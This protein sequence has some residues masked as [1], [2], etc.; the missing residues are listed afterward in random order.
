MSSPVVPLGPSRRPQGLLRLR[1]PWSRAG[2]CSR[3]K[4]AQV[5]RVRCVYGPRRG[6]D[7]AALAPRFPHRNFSAAPLPHLFI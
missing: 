1:G 5:G 7:Y 4:P 3:E 2:G 6:E